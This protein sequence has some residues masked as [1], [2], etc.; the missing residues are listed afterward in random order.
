MPA[1]KLRILEFPPLVTKLSLCDAKGISERTFERLAKRGLAP[2]PF[3]I[4]DDVFYTLESIQR[5]ERKVSVR[6]NT[7]LTD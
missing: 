1:R 6:A 3:R 2:K 5:W 7:R 4:I